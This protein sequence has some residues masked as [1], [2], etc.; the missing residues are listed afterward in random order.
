MAYFRTLSGSAGSGGMHTYSTTEQ[1]V[2]TWIDGSTI[3]ETTWEFSTALWVESN[4][5]TETDIDS[6]T[7]GKIINIQVMG[8]T[9]ELFD[10]FAASPTGA[11]HVRLLSARP[12]QGMYV[13][14]LVMQYTKPQASS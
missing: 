12:T 9:N 2:G 1:V 11:Q 3:Y 6:S 13:K 4:T 5:W 7:I 14:W 10:F 8:E